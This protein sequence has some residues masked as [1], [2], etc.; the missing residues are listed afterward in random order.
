MNAASSG[1]TFA[2]V[3]ASGDG[4]RLGQSHGP[5]HLVDL[6]GVPIIVWTAARLLACREISGVVIV[7]QKQH[8]QATGEALSSALGDQSGNVIFATGKKERMESFLS[9]FTALRKTFDVH[10]KDHVIL[11]DANRP[12]FSS[13]QTEELIRLSAESGAACLA[14]PVVNGVARAEGKKIVEVPEKAKYFE[15]VTPEI[16]QIANLLAALRS[17]SR[18]PQSLVEFALSLGVQPKIV[19]SSSTNM[20]LTYPEDVSQLHSISSISD[21]ATPAPEANRPN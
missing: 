6:H 17:K 14:R 20:K 3:L 2:V 11:A 5:K 7:T 21:L 13:S 4:R 1:A 18:L 8:R 15:F 19:T 12:L 16:L 10:E 9:G